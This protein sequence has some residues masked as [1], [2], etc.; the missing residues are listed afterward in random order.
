MTIKNR[1]SQ[2]HR[3]RTKY[4]RSSMKDTFEIQELWKQVDNSDLDDVFMD[5]ETDFIE[6]LSKD[7]SEDE[8]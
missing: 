6:S 4:H 8:S 7:K 2:V 3:D 5:W 1:G